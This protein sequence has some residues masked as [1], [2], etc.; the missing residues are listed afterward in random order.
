MSIR[1][2]GAEFTLIATPSGTDLV[3]LQHYSTNNS[4]WTSVN[5]TLL[6]LNA[7]AGTIYPVQIFVNPITAQAGATFVLF[8]AP[9]AGTITGVSAAVSGTFTGTNIVITPSVYHLGTPTAVT[10]GVVTLVDTSSAAGY[11]VSVVPTAADTFLAGDTVTATI[12]GGV[13]TVNGVVTL[14]VQRTA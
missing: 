6:N 9:F 11:S 10:G 4:Y 5:S 2:T 3:E 13:G 1:Q 7:A 12:T 8:S 14:Y